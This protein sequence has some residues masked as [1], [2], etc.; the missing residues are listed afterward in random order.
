M[1]YKKGGSKVVVVSDSDVVGRRLN[2]VVSPG[3]I[4]CYATWCPHCQTKVAK[5]KSLAKELDGR[6]SLYALE[7]DKNKRAARSIGV[8]GYPTF[9]TVSANGEVGKEEMSFDQAIEYVRGLQSGGGRKRKPSAW[10]I[11]VK[12]MMAKKGVTLGEASRMAKKEYKGH[13]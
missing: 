9:F 10:N 12:R 13:L 6:A 11:L 8:R 5:Y 7:A 1:L 4:Q 3:V 2:K